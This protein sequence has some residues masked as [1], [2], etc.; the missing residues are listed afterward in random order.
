VVV[1]LA[2]AL[3]RPGPLRPDL[4][5]V[6]GVA[7]PQATLTDQRAVAATLDARIG[8]GSVAF[9]RHGE[10][11]FL[12]RRANSLPLIYWNLAAWHHLRAPE[13]EGYFACARRLLD[14][15]AAD[16]VVTPKR[17]GYH[18]ELRSG[19]EVV[20]FSSENGR[21]AV[22]VALRPEQSRPRR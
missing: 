21:Y 9:L 13:S 5:L 3:A 20:V 14:E 2:L 19:Y 1:L 16:A 7:D 17:L 22:P 8:A 15:A 6:T 4:R 12:M 18:A 11:L 10:L